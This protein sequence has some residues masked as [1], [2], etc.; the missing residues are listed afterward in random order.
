MSRVTMNADSSFLPFGSPVFANTVKKS[1]MP[2]L[3]IQILV[4]FSTQSS[5]SRTA[6]VLIEAASEPD[7][8]SVRQN[9]AIIS[10]LASRG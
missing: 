9:A 2:P 10:P 3:V 1:A 7:V 8:G 4:P 5:P 6:V